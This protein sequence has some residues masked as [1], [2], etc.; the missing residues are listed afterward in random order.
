MESNIKSFEDAKE[1]LT[2][3]GWKPLVVSALG[4]KYNFF[5]VS[6]LGVHLWQGGGFGGWTASYMLGTD[7]LVHVKGEKFTLEEFI[8]LFNK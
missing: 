2:S 7:M 1:L 4:G 5:G 8:I 6:D 3:L